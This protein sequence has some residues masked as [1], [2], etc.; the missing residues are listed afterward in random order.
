ML[1]PFLAKPLDLHADLTG[2]VVIV[3]GGTG[4]IGKAAAYQLSEW[5]AARVIIG[6]RNEQKGN[7]VVAEIKNGTGRG[8]IEAWPLELADLESVRA[9]AKRFK[10]CGAGRLDLLLNNA[11]LVKNTFKK[12]KDG[13][14]IMFQVNFLSH[15]LLTNL[16]LDELKATP[17]ARVVHTSSGMANSAGKIDLGNLNGEKGFS[18]AR[19]YGNSK[20]LQIIYSN[21][22]NR[23]LETTGFIG[24]ESNLN[25]LPFSY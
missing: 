3:T 11:G 20:L 8:N 25:H 22:L 23:R 4:G 2:K 17:G 19:F 7:A 18:T 24:C 12:T 13:F 16:L 15:F 14:E 5:N 1:N 6:C 9:F 21:E 10:E